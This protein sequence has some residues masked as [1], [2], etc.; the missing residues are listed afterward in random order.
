M[1]NTLLALF[2]SATL[3]G[4]AGK[5]EKT[6]TSKPFTNQDDFNEFPKY[7]D[8][9][10]TIEDVYDKNPDSSGGFSVT[11]KDTALYIQDG[12]KPIAHKFREAR[13]VNSQKT[14]VLVQIE[15]GAGSLSPFYII[16]LKEGVPNAVAL[17]L[18]SNGKGDKDFAKGLQEITRTTL[19]VNNDFVV[20]TVRGK[21]YPIKRKN[22]GEMI[23]G[24]FIL[25]SADKTTLVFAA[26]KGLYQVNYLTGETLNLPVPASVLNSATM[27]NE[28]Q[29]NYSWEKNNRGT[30]FLKENL[31]DDRIVDISEFK[32]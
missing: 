11:L 2:L 17:S 28:I 29:Q 12:S 20:A 16:T 7:K 15:D 3:F 31:D 8:K 10:L 5:L 32:K 13:F 27:V 26:E 19:V 6:L 21:V 18:A 1:R 14:A 25:Y 24:N 22:P 30:L 9:I 4:C 23:Q